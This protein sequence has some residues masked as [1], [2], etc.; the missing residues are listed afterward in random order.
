MFDVIVAVF[1][2]VAVFAV[3]TSLFTLYAWGAG[4]QQFAA[5]RAAL[6]SPTGEDEPVSAWADGL[7]QLFVREPAAPPVAAERPSDATAG[8][9]SSLLEW[10]SA[11]GAPTRKP[12]S[13]AT[14]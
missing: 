9:Q 13:A 8:R 6:S 11:H 14:R 7:R 3:V 1:V 4:P 12:R 2:V 5:W 10:Y